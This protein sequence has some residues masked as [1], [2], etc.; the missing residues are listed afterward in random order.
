MYIKIYK[1][2]FWNIKKYGT[3]NEKQ[4]E[5]LLFVILKL[6][7]QSPRREQFGKQ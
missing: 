5:I 1:T 6:L 3:Y 2:V 4:K 7:L